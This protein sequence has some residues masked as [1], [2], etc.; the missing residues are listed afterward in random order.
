MSDQPPIKT[1]STRVVFQSRWTTLLEDEIERPG[2]LRGSYAVI[3]KRR[4]ALIVPWDGERLHLVRQWRYPTKAW[5]IEFP[6]GTISAPDG[7]DRQPEQDE[8]PEVIARTELKE[9]LGFTAGRL[10]PLGTIAF[11][12]GISNQLCDLWLATELTAGEAEPEP[13]EEGLITALPVTPAELESLLDMGEITDA[14]TV[15]AWT[16]VQRRGLPD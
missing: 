8:E 14:A 2:G 11:A 6:Q 5:S 1:T 7:A 3:E 15:A 16:L 12:P 9:E 13:E 4:A 10:E